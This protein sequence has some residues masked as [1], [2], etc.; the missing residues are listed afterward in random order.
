MPGVLPKQ[1]FRKWLSK[2][3]ITLLFNRK[4]KEKEVLR[5][6]AIGGLFGYQHRQPAE[7]NG[8]LQIGS[9]KLL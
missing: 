2:A 7:R 8:S 1:V 6:A 3:K 4:K 5:H 9:E